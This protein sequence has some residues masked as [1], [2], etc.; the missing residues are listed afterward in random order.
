MIC[1]IC[2]R[3]S[4]ISEV[5]ASELLEHLEQ[6][7]Y[8]YYIHNDPEPTISNEKTFRQDFLVILKRLSQR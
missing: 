2:S 8:R 7:F 5:N 4:S 6:M 3:I 1:E